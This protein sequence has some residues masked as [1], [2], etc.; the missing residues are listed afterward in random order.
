MTK[1]LSV[2]SIDSNSID[3]WSAKVEVI[4][5]S[6]HKSIANTQNSPKI[7]SDFGLFFYFA[8]LY[9]CTYEV[10]NSSAFYGNCPQPV[11]F[12]VVAAAAAIDV[13]LL[14]RYTHCVLSST[15]KTLT[16]VCVTLHGVHSCLQYTVAHN[17]ILYSAIYRT[18]HSSF[19]NMFLQPP[20]LFRCIVVF[21]TNCTVL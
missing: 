4:F 17:P 7:I 1:W 3:Q 18:R 9:K 20:P 11:A 6:V 5:P 10:F 15:E 2:Y 14:F 19:D 16:S 13:G 12:A 21:I 8:L